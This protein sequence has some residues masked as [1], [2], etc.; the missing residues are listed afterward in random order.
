MEFGLCTFADMQ[1][2]Y[3]SG[4]A[5]ITNK[6]YK[7]LMEEVRLA[8]ELGVGGVA[9]GQHHRPDYAVSSPTTVLAAAAMITQN[10]RRSNGVTVLSSDE[11]IRVLQQCA[12][13]QQFSDG[14]A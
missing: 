3:V 13:S 4:E 5:M 10:I 11:P 2:E 1:P 9:I 8:D 12:T 7:E 14:S 6:R